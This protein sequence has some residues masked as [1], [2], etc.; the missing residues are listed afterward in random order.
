MQ[1]MS[2]RIGTCTWRHLLFVYRTSVVDDVQ[3]TPFFL[4]HGRDARLPTDVLWGSTDKIADDVSQYG[5]LVTRRLRD[6]FAIARESRKATDARRKAYYDAR[7]ES[8]SF[9]LGAL[10]LL[11]SLVRKPRLSPKLPPCFDSPFRVQS[12]LSPVTNEPKYYG[13][14]AK[15]HQ[16]LSS[17]TCSS[18]FAFK[19]TSVRLR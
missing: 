11:H 8:V 3:N 14:R 1:T 10:V 16:I 19:C 18:R 4:V 7:H 2:R 13:S 5:I 6:A 17:E 12:R 15:D 9:E